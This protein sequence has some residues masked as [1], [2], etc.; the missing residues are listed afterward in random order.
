MSIYAITATPAW[1]RTNPCKEGR[2]GVKTS[3]VVATTLA[4]LSVARRRGA[5]CEAPPESRNRIEAKCGSR[6]INMTGQQSLPHAYIAARVCW[7]DYEKYTETVEKQGEREGGGEE[8]KFH[9]C[10]V[11]NSIEWFSFS[12]NKHA[13]ATKYWNYTRIREDRILYVFIAFSVFLLNIHFN[14]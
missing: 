10:A 13:R 2:C 6:S 14:F 8:E 3:A 12:L 11:E 4:C 7:T 5:V 9:V 1:R